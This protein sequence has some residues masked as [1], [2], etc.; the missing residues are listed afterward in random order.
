M[1]KIF[2]LL[3][4]YLL[5]FI[6]LKTAIFKGEKKKE[7]KKKNLFHHEKKKKKDSTEMK[8]KMRLPPAM[9]SAFSFSRASS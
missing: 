9:F 4:F 1:L 8:L 6:G 7:N 5:D 2:F 3:Y